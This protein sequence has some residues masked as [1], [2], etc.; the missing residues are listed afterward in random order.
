MTKVLGNILLNL[1]SC[2]KNRGF[3]VEDRRR[4]TT[5]FL[6]CPI[7]ANRIIRCRN[8]VQYSCTS[9]PDF[10]SYTHRSE[11]YS[12]TYRFILLAVYGREHLGR[13][14]NDATPEKEWIKFSLS[15]SGFSGKSKLNFLTFSLK[16]C[17]FF[18]ATEALKDEENDH[19]I[20]KGI[21]FMMTFWK[22][23]PCV[24]FKY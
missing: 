18:D 22:S 17:R 10:N 6:R 1:Q 16:F 4:F 20:L 5:S 23:F 13:C 24:C 19:K 9:L 12:P 7:L 14:Q 3:A 8:C 15:L 21:R 2:P 11:S